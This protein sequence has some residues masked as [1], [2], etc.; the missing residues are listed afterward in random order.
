MG[1]EARGVCLTS[2]GFMHR[3]TCRKVEKLVIPP[4][5]HIVLPNQELSSMWSGWWIGGRLYYPAVC[6]AKYFETK[7]VRHFE[8]ANE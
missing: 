3:P 4:K 8:W 2:A 5:T 7:E 6:C 1:E